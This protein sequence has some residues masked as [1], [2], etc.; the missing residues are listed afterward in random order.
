MLEEGG[1]VVD[2]H[3]GGFLPERLVHLVVV[4]RADNTTLY[5]RLAQ[6]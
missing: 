2:T 6:R 4:L 1:C 5:D 3:S